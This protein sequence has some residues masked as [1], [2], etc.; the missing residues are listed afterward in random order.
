MTLG[1][2][3]KWIAMNQQNSNDVPKTIS[4]KSAS[5]TEGAG[6]FKPI[7]QRAPDYAK[8]R[9]YVMEKFSKTLAYLAK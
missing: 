8:L 2:R 5:R 1:T 6:S 9:A 3:F 7:P 4:E